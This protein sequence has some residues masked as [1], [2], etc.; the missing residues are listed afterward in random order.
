[1]GEQGLRDDEWVFEDKMLVW[2]LRLEKT[3]FAPFVVRTP[4]DGSLPDY[5]T[6]EWQDYLIS[7][8]KKGNTIWWPR[9][10]IL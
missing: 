5:P 8:N 6:V 7:H 1:L 2:E 3:V 9:E 10:G 4:I